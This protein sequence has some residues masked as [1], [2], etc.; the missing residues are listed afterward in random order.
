INHCVSSHH[1][2]AVIHSTL[3]TRLL[4]VGISIDSDIKLVETHILQNHSLIK[5]CTLSHCWGKIQP[6]RLTQNSRTQ[7]LTKIPFDSLPRTFQDS[8]SVCRW[9]RVRYLW[10]DSLCIIQDSNE[11]WLQ[12]ASLMSHVY[13]GSYLNIA[14]LDAADCT[15]GLFFRRDPFFFKALPPLNNRPL[16]HRGWVFQERVL[17]PRVLYFGQQQILWQ[18]SAMDD[19]ITEVE[20]KYSHKMV[21]DFKKSILDKQWSVTAWI[22]IVERYTTLSLT[23][24]GDRLLA[25]EGIARHIQQQSGEE[26][27][28]GLWRKEMLPQLLWSTKWTGESRENCAPSWSWGATQAQ[29]HWPLWMDRHDCIELSAIIGI[30]SQTLPSTTESTTAAALTHGVLAIRGPLFKV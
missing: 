19:I 26:Y 9:L 16:S 1:E 20:P 14:A 21:A 17:C 30:Q 11:D 15:N 23:V 10:I 8:I 27:H 25:I 18:C 29:I 13:R 12:E 5:Y 4:D 7:F 28:A 2:C 24:P 3:P 22:K 6:L